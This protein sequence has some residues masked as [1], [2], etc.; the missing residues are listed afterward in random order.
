MPK[1]AKDTVDKLMLDA[2]AFDI[3]IVDVI[4]ESLSHRHANGFR[5]KFF[6][7]KIL[8]TV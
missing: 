2:I 4:D 1:D 3:L 6:S 7:K 8:F 5:H